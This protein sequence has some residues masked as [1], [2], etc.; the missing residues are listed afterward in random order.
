MGFYSSR[1]R[2]RIMSWKKVKERKRKVTALVKLEVFMGMC[3]FF[4]VKW[5]IYIFLKNK[6]NV[7]Y[8]FAGTIWCQ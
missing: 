7:S 2:I 4:S 1:N 3:V 5:H 6:A 8:V